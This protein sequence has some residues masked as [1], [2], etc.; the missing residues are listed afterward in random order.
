VSV[1]RS[2]QT[3][4]REQREYSQ[5][6][7]VHP[8]QLAVLKMKQVRQCTHTETNVMVF[9][10]LL[11]QNFKYDLLKNQLQNCAVN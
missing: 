5:M 11:L 6:R 9:V 4:R 7:R 8:P 1:K 10:L 2:A 3:T